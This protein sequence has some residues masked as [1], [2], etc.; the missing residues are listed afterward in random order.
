LRSGL[1]SLCAGERDAVA[2]LR[3]LVRRVRAA[4]SVS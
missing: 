2:I 4:A 1:A 3:R